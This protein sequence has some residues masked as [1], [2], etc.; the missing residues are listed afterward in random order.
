MRVELSH[1]TYLRE[2]LSGHSTYEFD[3]GRSWSPNGWVIRCS[4]KGLSWFQKCIRGFEGTAIV[5]PPKVIRTSNTQVAEA[6]STS[7]EKHGFEVV[8]TR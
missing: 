7:L 2:L 8:L 6:L 3:V 4:L 1:E 5:C